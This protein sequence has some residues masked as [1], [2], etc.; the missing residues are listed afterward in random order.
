MKTIDLP[1]LLIAIDFGASST[2]IVGSMVGDKVCTPAIISPYCLEVDESELE[3]NPDFTENSVWVKLGL[4][5]YAVGNLAKIQ[6]HS[7]LT[8]KALKVDSA[9]QK[10][11]AA[12]AVMAQ[13]LKLPPTFRLS[14]VVVLPPAESSYLEVYQTELNKAFKQLTTPAGKLKPKLTSLACYP[15]GMGILS[16]HQDLD[17]ATKSVVVL[18]LGFR[19]ASIFSSIQGVLSGYHSSNLGF[20]NLVKQVAG[21]SSGYQ[22]EELVGPIDTYRSTGA[23]RELEFILKSATKYR[24]TELK[25]LKTEIARATTSH[26][27]QLQSWLGEVMPNRVDTILL[28]GGT[29]DYLQNDLDAYLL[30]KLP[31]GRTKDAELYIHIGEK[32]PVEIQKLGLGNRFTDI[33]CLWQDLQRLHPVVINN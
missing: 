24:D 7:W 4:N 33:Y 32:L 11:C 10:T 1:H 28:C 3:M 29:A 14:L 2:K 20:Y 16:W 17:L 12:V 5:S 18:M 8:V 15:E 26:V 31:S 19:N 23:D 13:K 27:Q 25:I 6:F 30:S 21:N 9:V 22:V